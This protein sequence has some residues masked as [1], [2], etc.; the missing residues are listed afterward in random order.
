MSSTGACYQFDSKVWTRD[1]SKK[2]VWTREMSCQL[3][4]KC[5][6]GKINWQS[7]YARGSREPTFFFLFFFRGNFQEKKVNK[8]CSVPGKN[9]CLNGHF[10]FHGEII[11][12]VRL[13]V[14]LIIKRLNFEVQ[15]TLFY[16]SRVGQVFEL[17]SLI[18]RCLQVC[19]YEL[20]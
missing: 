4:K 1:A 17:W 9:I 20:S 16:K 18:R 2:K 5:F 3:S 8:T 11:A 13:K 14:L 19:D 10:P 6:Q 15:D 7:H 12:S